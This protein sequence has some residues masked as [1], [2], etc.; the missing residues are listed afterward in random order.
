MRLKSKLKMKLL[1]YMLLF[2]VFAIGQTKQEFETRIE[3]DVLPKAMQNFINKLP[4]DTKRIR[5]YKEV[6]GK[7]E[8]FEAKFKHDKNHYSCEFN[9]NG[10]LEDIEKLIKKKHL[11]NEAFS[12]IERYLQNN[13][14]KRKFLKIQEQY[15][16]ESDENPI[17]I[18]KSI[19]EE[20]SKIS[21]YEI[22]IEVTKDKNRALKEFQFDADGKFINLRDIA[23][24]SY[25]H[26]LY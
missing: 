13:F 23:P 22:I 17:V 20:T 7:K 21:G 16:P 24:S 19:F 9:T 11:K 8:S 26:V 25:G 14:Q 12:N 10:T 15:L 5:F 6:D 4:K 3:K 2:S 1:L 18:L